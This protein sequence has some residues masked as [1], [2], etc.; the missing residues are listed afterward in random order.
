MFSSP[1]ALPSGQ[2]ELGSRDGPWPSDRSTDEETFQ[3]LQLA[4]RFK[5]GRIVPGY[6]EMDIILP[7]FSLS[8]SF[9]SIS[10]AIFL[11]YLESVCVSTAFLNIYICCVAPRFSYFEV[12]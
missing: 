7:L 10:G 11:Q 8:T 4:K 5:G 3:L 12:K 9:N 2:N 1:P 6:R